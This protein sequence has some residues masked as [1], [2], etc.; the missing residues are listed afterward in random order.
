MERFQMNNN[1]GKTVSRNIENFHGNVQ[2][3]AEEFSVNFAK[4]SE[5]IRTTQR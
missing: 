4:F 2:K 1:I 5:L 3:T